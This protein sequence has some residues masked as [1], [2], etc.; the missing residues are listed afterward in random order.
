CRIYN[1]ITNNF[2]DELFKCVRQISLFDEKPFE[3]EFFLRMEKSFPFLENISIHNFQPQNNKSCTESN[4]DNQY[5]S[6]VKYT[7]LT[8]LSL[9]KVHDDYIEQ[10]LVYTKVSLPNNVHLNISY[11]SLKR[12][13]NN[14]TRNATQINFDQSGPKAS[15]RVIVVKNSFGLSYDFSRKNPVAPNDLAANAINNEWIKLN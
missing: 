8:N 12:V 2:S 13:T 7:Y 15:S 6:I 4:K 5:L 11:E 9:I 1:Y 3:H 10:F 14:F